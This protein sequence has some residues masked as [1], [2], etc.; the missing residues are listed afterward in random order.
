MSNS[1]QTAS[2]GTVMGNTRVPRAVIHKQILDAAA[3]K[4]DA[5]MRAIADEVSGA[6][7]EL[8]EKVFNE[9]GDPGKSIDHGPDKSVAAT[10]E[11]VDSPVADNASGEEVT[12][13]QSPESSDNESVLEFNRNQSPTKTERKDYLKETEVTAN[14]TVLTSESGSSE[15]S[16]PN[17]IDGQTVDTAEEAVDGSASAPDV[18]DPATLTDTQLETLRVVHDRPDATQV[19]LASLFDITSASVSQRVNSVDGFEWENRRA[20]TSALFETSDAA[21]KAPVEADGGT[22]TSFSEEPNVTMST[23]EVTIDSDELNMK[24][25]NTTA[26]IDSDTTMKT[27]STKQEYTCDCAEQLAA[28]A[29]QV[30]RLEERLANRS[31]SRSGSLVDD[32]DLA[33]KVVHA[34]LQSDQI[35]ENE[36]LQLLQNMMGS[37]EE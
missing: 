18:P 9:Y 19:E 3:S 20:F 25:E 7:T 15:S 17:T 4:P 16:R 12:E 1:Q 24:D 37:T 8:V 35:S 36:E 28:V 21:D 11:S 31:Q 22:D 5:S 34:C 30:D 13:E 10:D 26:T 2:N 6:T 32:P 29:D 33:H 27:D 23:G 14:S